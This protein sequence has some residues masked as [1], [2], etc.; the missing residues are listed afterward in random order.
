MILT[1]QD[2]CACYR[3]EAPDCCNIRA[4]VDG[5]DFVIVPDPADPSTPYWLWDDLLLQ[6]ARDGDF[7][8]RLVSVAALN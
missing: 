1:Y 3:I 7:G 5:P 2:G 4:A 6:A 8:L